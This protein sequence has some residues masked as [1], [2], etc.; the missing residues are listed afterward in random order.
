V[1]AQDKTPADR[2]PQDRPS[3]ERAASSLSTLVK[4][5]FRVKLSLKEEEINLEARLHSL[6]KGI[7]QL[8]ALEPQIFSSHVFLTIR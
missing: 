7:T 5:C 8:K 1:D 2:A 4:N 6:T 3:G